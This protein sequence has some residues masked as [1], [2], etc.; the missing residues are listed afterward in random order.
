MPFDAAFGTPLQMVGMD[1]NTVA[2]RTAS[3]QVV[4]IDLR[5]R[6]TLSASLSFA[7]PNQITLTFFSTAGANYRIERTD[8]VI[9]PTWVTVRDNIAG[10]GSAIAETLSSSTGPTSFYRVIQL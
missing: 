1:V 5:D 4:V 10:T 3:G 2:V 7:G 6:D 9:N 8:R